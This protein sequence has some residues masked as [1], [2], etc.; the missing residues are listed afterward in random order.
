MSLISKKFDEFII[1]VGTVKILNRLITP[2]NEI[3][4]ATSPLA[5][6]VRMLDVT[7]PGAD[8][9]IINPKAISGGISKIKIRMSVIIGNKIT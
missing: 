9:S 3:D 2:V 6:F 5:N 4:N 8:A 1:I 7:P